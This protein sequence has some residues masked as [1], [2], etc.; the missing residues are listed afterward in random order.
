MIDI[1]ANIM[2][3]REGFLL[4]AIVSVA[5]MIPALFMI[6]RAPLRVVS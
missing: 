4:I 1:Q 5:A 3:Y 2:S 6:R